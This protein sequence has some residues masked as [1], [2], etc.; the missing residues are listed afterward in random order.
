MRNQ[1][2]EDGKYPLSFEIIYGMAFGPQDGQPVKTRKVM[3]PP[4]SM[5]A[6][7]DGLRKSPE[8]ETLPKP[9]SWAMIN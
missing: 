8:S 9:I 3:S 1:L 7:R 4:F 6:L 2:L 5:D